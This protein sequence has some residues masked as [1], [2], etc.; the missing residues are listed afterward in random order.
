[1]TPRAPLAAL[2]LAASL[3]ACAGGGERA[4]PA[5]PAPPTPWERVLDL[6]VGLPDAFLREGGLTWNSESVSV[7]AGRMR[8]SADLREE[9]ETPPA[10]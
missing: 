10:R 3:A 7:T 5:E 9:R 2:A 6:V 1:M 8:W 4:A